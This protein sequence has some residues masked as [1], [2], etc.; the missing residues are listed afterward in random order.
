LQEEESKDPAHARMLQIIDNNVQRMDLMVKDILE[1]N[2]RD[3]TRQ[4]AISIQEFL[5]EF[6]SE[7]CQVEK[8]PHHGFVLEL[9]Q[10]LLLINFDRRHLN[11]ILWNL[12]RNGWRHSRQ[13]SGSL[14]L[15][16]RLSQLS[17]GVLLEI[18]DDGPGVAAD[19]RQHLFEPFF[20]TESTG[21]G[22]GLYIARELCEANAASIHYTGHEIGGSFTIHIK[23][24]MQ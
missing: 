24:A 21:T 20:T 2:R 10:A 8:I 3:R 1:L 5:K 9:T 7:F 4:E 22:L 18:A 16:L 15:S 14:R 23:Q 17:Q 12:C 13:E 11:Q 19:I 6:H